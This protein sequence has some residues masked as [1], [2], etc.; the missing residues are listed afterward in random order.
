ML[1]V[2]RTEN[3]YILNRREAS[4]LESR[5]DAIMPRDPHSTSSRGY[6]IRSLYFDTVTDR[7]CAEK[8]EGL[9]IHE[10]IRLRIYGSSDRIIKLECKHKDGAMQTKKSMFVDRATCDALSRGDYSVLRDSQDPQA[11]FF[12]HKL[13]RGMV[14]KVIISYQRLSFCIPTNNIRITFDTEVRATESCLDLF[15]EPFRPHPVFPPDMVILEVKFNNFLLSYIKSALECI[16]RSSTSCSKYFS[17]RQFY[18]HL[19]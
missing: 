7:C 9:Q 6:E 11:R 1:Q 4:F 14:P 3:K 8:D 5:L 16:S 15:A 13:C 2:K 12:Y 19:L 18:R 17:G 10:K